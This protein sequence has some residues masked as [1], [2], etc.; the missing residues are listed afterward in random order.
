MTSMNL[1]LWRSFIGFQSLSC[2]AV[3]L[4]INRKNNCITWIVDALP[5]LWLFCA[6]VFTFAI[7][8]LCTAFIGYW[9]CSPLTL[10]QLYSS[11]S[12]PREDHSAVDDFMW[13]PGNVWYYWFTLLLVGDLVKLAILVNKVYFR[14]VSSYPF[15]REDNSSLNKC[16]KPSGQALSPPPPP[17]KKKKKV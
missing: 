13:H 9:Q 17:Q 8:S 10:S 3:D 7:N 4:K 2:D 16:L 11:S 5:I 12:H 14:G 1:P 15:L 6:V